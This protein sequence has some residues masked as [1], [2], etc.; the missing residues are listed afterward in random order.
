[1][2]PPTLARILRQQAESAGPSTSL[3]TGSARRQLPGGLL[4]HFARSGDKRVLTLTRRQPGPT[5]AERET[6]RAAFGVDPAAFEYKAVEAE[7]VIVSVEWRE[8]G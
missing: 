4:V 5:A 8:D 7:Y 6:W 2:T 1:M 3:R